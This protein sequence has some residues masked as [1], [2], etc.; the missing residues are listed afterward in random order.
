MEA[1]LERLWLELA[2]IAVQLLIVGV[3]QWLRNRPPA[4]SGAL[5][6]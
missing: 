4:P 1:F 6:T 3:V 5:A 2:A